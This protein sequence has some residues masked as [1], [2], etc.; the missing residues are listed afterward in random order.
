MCTAETASVRATL[1]G[2]SSKTEGKVHVHIRCVRSC[3]IYGSELRQMKVEHETMLRQNQNEYATLRWLRGFTMK[4]R[5]K[6]AEI[7][8]LIKTGRLRRFGHDE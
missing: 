5:R 6:S 4:E 1:A 7:R 8:E 3:P 2:V